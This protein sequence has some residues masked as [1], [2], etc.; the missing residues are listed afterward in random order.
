MVLSARVPGTHVP[1]AKEL[2]EVMKVL[3]EEMVPWTERWKAEGK[4]EGIAEGKAQGRQE[5]L[6]RIVQSRFGV[7]V[8]DNLAALLQP[9][10]SE[11]VLDELT[12]WVLSCRSG[13]DLLARVRH[14]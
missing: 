12:D 1:E 14:G 5:Q 3:D 8:A 13:E 11:K 6:I 7:I 4:A 10:G 9:V 2:A